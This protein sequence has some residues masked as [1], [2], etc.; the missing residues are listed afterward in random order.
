MISRRHYCFLAIAK[1]QTT[2]KVPEQ[3]SASCFQAQGLQQAL[4][5]EKESSFCF[6]ACPALAKK[7]VSKTL[8]LCYLLQNKGV[9]TSASEESESEESEESEESGKPSRMMRL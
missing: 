7:L 1:T 5:E 3:P 8:Q 2:D 6:Q 9:Y 4:G